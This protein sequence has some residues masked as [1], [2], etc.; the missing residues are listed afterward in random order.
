MEN[1]KKPIKK[2]VVKE[3]EPINVREASALEQAIAELDKS[4]NKELKSILFQKYGVIPIELTDEELAL[5][6]LWTLPTHELTDE[7]VAQCQ[8]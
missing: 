6:L 2:E 8:S 3:P 7:G 4:T 1:I 5:R